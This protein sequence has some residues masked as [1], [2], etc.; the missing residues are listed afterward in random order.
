MRSRRFPKTFLVA[1][2]LLTLLCVAAFA[3]KPPVNAKGQVISI[4]A[5]EFIQFQPYK[6]RVEAEKRAAADYGVKLTILQPPGVDGASHAETILNALNQNFDALIIENDWPGNYDEALALAQ[7]KGII[8][9]DVHVPNPNKAPYISQ[10]TID[11][12]GYGITAADKL[13]ELT[14]GKA[15]VLFLL[16][17]PDIPNQATQRQSFIDRA[18]AKWP[19]IKVVDT[20]FTKNDPVNAAKILE[21]SLKANPQ[22]DTAIWL[23]AATV[24][25]GADV[26]KEMKLLGKVKIIGIDDPPDLVESIRKGEV[27]GS[28][29]QNF[30]KQGYEAVRNIVDYFNKQPFPKE[31]DAGIVLITKENVDS[32]VPD[33]WKPVALKGQPY[34]N[35]K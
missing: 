32:Y 27:F 8:L 18:K 6:V 5:I 22:I 1:G 2:V 33:M 7:K 12:T 17:S 4:A 3:Q 14:G 9:V 31:T 34:S 15:N 10:I 21:A 16:N 11:N 23:E 35:L 29:N 24:S 25:V 20:Q 30:Q 19:G 28:F 13:G 26:L